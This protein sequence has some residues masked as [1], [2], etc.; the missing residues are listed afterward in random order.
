VSR[1]YGPQ[2]DSRIAALSEDDLEFIFNAVEA[3]WTTPQIAREV[4]GSFAAVYVVSKQ[5]R[6]ELAGAGIPRP[7]RRAA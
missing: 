2:L 4:T 7:K 5:A 6:A 1:P 3:G